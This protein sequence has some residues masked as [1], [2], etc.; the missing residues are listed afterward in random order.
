MNLTNA[1]F[2]L[3]ITLCF[4]ALYLVKT[5]TYKMNLYSVSPKLIGPPTLHM[6]FKKC[7]IGPGAY[8]EM[9]SDL[10][11]SLIDLQSKGYDKISFKSHLIRRGGVK[12]LLKFIEEN[13]MFCEKLIFQ[14]TPLYHRISNKRL[15]LVHKNTKIKVHHESAYMT[16]RLSKA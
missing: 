16:I 3:S 14:K 2:I 10:C 8:K 9:Y 15:M 1:F 6:R 4:V 5:F 12:E 13:A 11:A 7:P